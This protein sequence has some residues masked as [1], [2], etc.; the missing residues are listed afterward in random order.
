MFAGMCRPER[1]HTE[2]LQPLLLVLLCAAG[3]AEGWEVQEDR[4]ASCNGGGAVKHS[5]AQKSEVRS[6]WFKP[7]SQQQPAAFPLKHARLRRR[8]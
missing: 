4:G 2:A 1:A 8:R 3:R 7:V 5:P 6:V